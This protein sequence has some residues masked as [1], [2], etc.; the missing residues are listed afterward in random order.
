MR[1]ID[2]SPLVVLLTAPVAMFLASLLPETFFLSENTSTIIIW[3]LLTLLVLRI[4]RDIRIHR[5][6]KDPMKS[7]ELKKE[8][9]R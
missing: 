3:V 6:M 4:I 9:D 5:I 1:R 8:L 7:S 2:W